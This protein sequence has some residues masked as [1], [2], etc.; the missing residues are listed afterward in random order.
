LLRGGYLV[1]EAHRHAKTDDEAQL[2][3]LLSAP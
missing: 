2:A 1:L 3:A